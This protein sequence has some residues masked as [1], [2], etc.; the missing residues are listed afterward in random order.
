[1]LLMDGGIRCMYTVG[2]ETGALEEVTNQLE[3]HVYNRI[4]PVELGWPRFTAR[5]ESLNG[6]YL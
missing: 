3:G 1:M 6:L 4:V 5:I 2:L